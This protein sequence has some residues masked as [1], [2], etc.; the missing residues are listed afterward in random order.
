MTEIVLKVP[1]NP[2]SVNQR[3]TDWFDSHFP[4]E[5]GSAGYHVWSQRWLVEH[6][7]VPRCLVDF[8]ERNHHSWDI[9]PCSCANWHV[10][11]GR[12]PVPK[13]IKLVTH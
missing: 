4:G 2:T 12:L 7:S 1:L 5:V 8:N 13:F 6:S 9:I 10:R 3:Q 11:E